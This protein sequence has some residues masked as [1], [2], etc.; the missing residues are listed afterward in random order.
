MKLLTTKPMDD[1]E[2]LGHDFLGKRHFC[3][4]LLFIFALW[5]RLV[6]LKFEEKQTLGDSK[7]SQSKLIYGTL[8]KREFIILFW[9]ELILIII[10]RYFDCCCFPLLL[11]LTG[12]SCTRNNKS[13]RFRVDSRSLFD[14]I[15]TKSIRFQFDWCSEQLSG[16]AQCVLNNIWLMIKACWHPG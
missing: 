15:D 3:W 12:L 5:A 14:H 6:S 9:S 1:L 8:S 16:L 11:K 4:V 13:I 2:K 10:T 7:R